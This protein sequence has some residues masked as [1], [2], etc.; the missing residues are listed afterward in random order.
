MRSSV[1]HIA[2]EGMNTVP[3]VDN[4]MYLFVYISVSAAVHSSDRVALIIS[5]E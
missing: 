5:E 1:S 3:T 2:T 4:V